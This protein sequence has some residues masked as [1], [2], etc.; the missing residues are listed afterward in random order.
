MIP[1]LEITTCTMGS[2]DAWQLTA[3][4]YMP[5]MALVFALLLLTR[6][7]PWAKWLSLPQFALIP[8]ATWVVAKYL[9]G[10]TIQG[11]HLC[12]VLRDPGFNGYTSS[13]WAPYWAP[14]MLIFIGLLCFGYWKVW[15]VVR[16]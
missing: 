11:N 4:F 6:N 12:A 7:I 14:A 8:W 16:S 2:E 15:R 10:V 1:A 13:W 5:A 3:I 9:I